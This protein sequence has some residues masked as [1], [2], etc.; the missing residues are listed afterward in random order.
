VTELVRA[1]DGGRYE[2]LEPISEGAMGAV[3]RARAGEREVAVKRLLN[4]GQAAR[5]EIEARLLSGLRH[6]GVVRVIDHFSDAGDSY[7]VMELVRGPDLAQALR[8]RGAPGLPLGEVLEIARQAADALEY[9]HK[10]QVVHRDV[11]PQNLIAGESRTVLVD[12]GVAR[13]IGDDAGTR[14]VGTP[15]YM[16]PEVMVGEGVSPRSDIYGLAAT[17]WT[18]LAG[19]PPAYGSPDPLSVPGVTRERE[20][21]LRRA[22]DLRP[23]RRFA[24]ASALA[25]E[26]GSPIGTAHGESMAA[27][28]PEAGPDRQRLLESLVRTVAGIFEAA[29]VSVALRD[30]VTS[31]LVFHAAWGTGAEGI[32]GVRLRPGEGIAGAALAGAEPVVVAECRS[33]ERFAAQIAAGTG[34]VPNT[35]LAVPLSREGV[36]VGVLSILDRRDGGPYGRGDVSRAELFAELTVSALG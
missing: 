8:E 35:L 20:Q 27:S 16:A 24:S 30:E 6:P 29:S 11:K 13:Q 18:L 26:I 33:D 5:F 3:F 10:Q 23:E 19:A 4:L 12:F 25:M 36:A 2:L 32:V 31:E 21:A 1:P 7:L 28:L 34:Y 22:L 17:L 14:G 15:H 9:V